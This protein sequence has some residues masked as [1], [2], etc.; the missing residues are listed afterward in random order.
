M[1]R[2]NKQLSHARLENGRKEKGQ[3]IRAEELCESRG[4][5]PGLPIPTSPYGL[6]GCKTTLEEA[7]PSLP[8]ATHLPPPPKKKKKKRRKGE[9]TM[10]P[11]DEERGGERR[12]QI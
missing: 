12:K 11:G 7:S 2:Q 6:C 3:K 10:T 9:E 8:P 4:G 1:K 5:R